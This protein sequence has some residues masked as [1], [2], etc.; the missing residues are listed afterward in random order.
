MKSKASG[1]SKPTALSIGAA[2]NSVTCAL[3]LQLD[4]SIYSI[5]QIIREARTLSIH[6]RQVKEYL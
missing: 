5:T 4:T 6:G 1:H 3:S 2:L